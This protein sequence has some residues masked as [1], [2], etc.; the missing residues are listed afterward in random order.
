MM[1]WTLEYMYL[2]KVMLFFFFF[3][4]IYPE[5][6]LLGHMVV[7]F[8]VFW[9]TSILFSTVAAPI[10][11]PTNSVW[12]FPFLHILA[13]ICYLCSFLMTAILTSVKWYLI[14]VLIC[15]SLMISD[16]EHLL[17]CLLA[18]SIS[19]LEN[20]LFSSSAHFL[21]RLFFLMLSCMS[22]LY[23]LDIS[24]LLVMSFANIFSHSVDCIFLS[25]MVF[26]CSAKAFKFN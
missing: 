7:L 13:N 22:C 4:D 11:I 9:E 21:I 2:F 10:Y 14:V 18:F 26:L 25:S 19:S 17:M 5:M 16:V 6:E 12:G 23:M 15:I 24:P 1:L 20:C 3:S 8:L